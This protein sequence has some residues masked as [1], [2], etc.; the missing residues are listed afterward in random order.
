MHVSQVRSH[1][2]HENTLEPRVLQLALNLRL[3]RFQLGQGASEPR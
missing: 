3:Q 2:K 1:T